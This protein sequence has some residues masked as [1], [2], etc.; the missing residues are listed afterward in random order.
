MVKKSTAVNV[1]KKFL[2]F[3]DKI[4]LSFAT[5]HIYLEHDLS[6]SFTK[7]NDHSPSIFRN[8]LRTSIKLSL[9]AEQL[10]FMISREKKWNH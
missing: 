1:T 9:N 2:V 10:H 7:I 5:G 8:S 4:L 6:Y 3:A